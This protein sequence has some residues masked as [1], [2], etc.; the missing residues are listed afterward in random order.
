MIKTKK[1]ISIIEKTLNT[2]ANIFG[3]LLL[4]AGVL[5]S[6]F[7][8]INTSRWYFALDD[9]N[10]WE[11]TTGIIKASQVVQKLS[12]EATGMDD[13]LFDSKSEAKIPL[14]NKITGLIGYENSN[15]D[16]SIK[17]TEGNKINRTMYT[18]SVNYSYSINGIDY[19]SS[20]ISGNYANYDNYEDAYQF[21]QLNNFI[22]DFKS[23]VYFLKSDPS[24]SVLLLETHTSMK[25][26]MIGSLLFFIIFTTV[27]IL[28]M[29]KTVIKDYR[30]QW[31]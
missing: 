13:N 15:L 29:K 16:Y 25:G 23:K 8:F 17:K 6:L 31:L 3:L 7:V 19:S 20:T 28:Y 30:Q 2:V 26:L 21:L 14:L 12:L 11:E 5:V 22:N 24:K 18:P 10:K 9:P 27:F 1:V 4:L